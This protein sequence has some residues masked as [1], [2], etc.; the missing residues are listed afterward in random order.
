MVNGNR[1]W[2]RPQASR[3]SYAERTI[4]VPAP[5]YDL[6]G[7]APSHTQWFFR[8]DR[9]D[10]ER[11]EANCA[12]AAGVGWKLV[13]R[14]HRNAHPATDSLAGT[15]TYGPSSP[16]NPSFASRSVLARTLNATGESR[17]TL[18]RW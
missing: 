15:D 18:S 16:Q 8:H 1:P 4:G 10:G 9:H 2:S 7:T 6:C 5:A 13:R 17:V 12:D 14:T 3:A 11:E